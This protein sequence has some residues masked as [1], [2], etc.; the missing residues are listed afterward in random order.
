MTF[1]LYL[2]ENSLRLDWEA[3]PSLPTQHE[4]NTNLMPTAPG[5]QQQSTIAEGL[6]TSAANRFTSIFRWIK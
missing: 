3:V 6:M 5:P 1:I 2:D 4:L